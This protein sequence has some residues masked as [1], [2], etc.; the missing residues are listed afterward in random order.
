MVVPLPAPGIRI[1]NGRGGPEGDLPVGVAGLL[2]V[3]PGAHDQID[4]PADGFAQGHVVGRGVAAPRVVPARDEIDRHVLIFLRRVDDVVLRPEL[5]VG[6]V[7]HGGDQPGFVLR[8]EL[9]RRHAP[10]RRQAFEI[11][12]SLIGHFLEHRG[13]AGIAHGS[14][15][16]AGIL[17]DPVPEPQLVGPG[18]AH[19]LPAQVRHGVHRDHGFQLRRVHKRAARAARRR[20]RTCRSCR[21]CHWTTTACRSTRRSPRRRAHR[22]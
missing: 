20:H 11:G 15:A 4:R 5:V 18:V 3:N 7:L 13:C 2:S 19:A 16:A 12:D 1:G 14:A 17:K 6:P 9:E 22:R 8:R 21:S 10:P